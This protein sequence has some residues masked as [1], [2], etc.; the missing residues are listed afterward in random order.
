[1]IGRMGFVSISRSQPAQPLPLS[2]RG[3]RHGSEGDEAK[4]R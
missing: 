2:A 4:G 3:G 1:M